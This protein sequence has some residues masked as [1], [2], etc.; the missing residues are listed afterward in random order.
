MK[1][2]FPAIF[3][4]ILTLIIGFINYEPGMLLTGGDNLHPEFNFWINIKRSLFAA[5]QEY[6]GPGLLGGMGHASDLLRQLFLAFMSLFI[7]I[8][9]VRYI[10]TMFTLFIGA[11]GSY[12]LIRY[13][14]RISNSSNTSILATLGALFYVFNLSTLQ[15]YYIPYEVFTN[16]FAAL[17]WQLLTFIWYLKSPSW[18]R[19]LVFSLVLL[20]STPAAYVPTIFVVFCLAITILSLFIIPLPLRRSNNSLKLTDIKL[21]LRRH[22]SIWLPLILVNAFWLFPFAHFTIQNAGINI[23]S[24]INQMV[25]ETNFLINKE[26]GDIQDVMLLKSFWLNNVEPWFDGNNRYM[27]LPWRE[28]L[29]NP[30]IEIIGFLLFAVVFLGAITG[31]RARNKVILGFVALFAFSMLMLTTATPPFSWINALIRDHV[32]II[33]QAFRFPF[34]KFSILTSLMYAIF[35]AFGAQWIANFIKSKL[36]SDTNMR[37]LISPICYSLLAICLFIFTLPYFK[38]DFIYAKEKLFFPNDYYQ[39]FDFFEKQDPTTRIANF[40]QHTFWEWNYYDWGYGGSGFLWYGIEQ[41]ILDRAFDVWS[42]TSENYYFEISHA[43]YSKNLKEFEDVLN[44]YNASWFIIDKHI[45]NPASPN[46]LFVKEL[47]EMVA[48]SPRVKKI[49]TFGKVD[50]YSLALQNPTSKFVSTLEKA[51]KVNSF[52][53]NAQDTAY[54][55]F[56]PYQTTNQNN[57]RIYPFRS[58]FSLKTVEDQTFR[59]TEEKNVLALTETIPPTTNTLTL[60]VPEYLTEEQVVPLDIYASEVDGELEINMRMKSPKIFVDNQLVWGTD[61][62]TTLFKLD[63]AYAKALKNGSLTLSL[64]MNG[65]TDLKLSSQSAIAESTFLLLHENNVF[66]L[67][68]N[69]N[70]PVDSIRISRA[71][72]TKLTFKEAKPFVL[73]ISNKERKV[74]ALYPKITDPYIH[75]LGKVENLNDVRR[76]DEFRKGTHKGI[77]TME[78]GQWVIKFSSNNAAACTSWYAHTLPHDQAYAVFVDAENI[79]GRGLH[80][81]IENIDQKYAT[82]ETYLPGKKSKGRYAFI[83]PPLEKFGKAYSFHLDNISIG[84]DATSNTVRRLAAYPIPYTFLTQITFS[85][86]NLPRY[87]SEGVGEA[88][89]TVTHPNESLYYITVTEG[90]PKI[91]SLS[92]SYDSGWKLYKVK[93]HESGIMHFMTL[94]LPFLFGSEEKNHIQIMN[95]SNGWILNENV[96]SGTD[97]AYVAVYFPQYFQYLGFTLL[98][99]LF[100]TALIKIRGEKKQSPTSQEA[101]TYAPQEAVQQHRSEASTQSHHTY[102]QQFEEESRDFY[103][104]QYTP[105]EQKIQP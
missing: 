6:Q 26:F 85:N 4:A 95:W 94:T 83:N 17:P 54:T 66:T 5:W 34:T 98:F 27:L 61:A 52:T 69:Q 22:M 93:N 44:K 33:N 36:P 29:A 79:Q 45:I 70:K 90:N 25:T 12:Y 10:F 55:S 15:A 39:L 82:L 42:S 99:I 86:S 57:D 76:C 41:P 100:A 89:L 14:L 60:E 75:F 40:P 19:V 73:P 74:T 87:F 71:D 102:S 63:E 56:G 46:A 50:V 51:P 8:D 58:L 53:R 105:V 65:I 7:P 28:H 9:A 77:K 92:Q 20:L 11:L 43:I 88:K 47:E 72:L 31:F 48:K 35:F 49:A 32:P 3:F 37:N 30:G 68:D 104:S 13:L 96:A 97:H 21:F 59:L 2:F 78:N 62:V 91:I 80:F 67:S 18:K 16:H 81:W 24:K 84:N 23:H 64:D 1:R 103:P 38:G 101:L